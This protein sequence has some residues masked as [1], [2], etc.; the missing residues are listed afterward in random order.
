M[1]SHGSEPVQVIKELF[2]R[3][4]QMPAAPP[5]CTT[6]LKLLLNRFR[7][8]EAAGLFLGLSEDVHNGSG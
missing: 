8:V 4:I 6:T 3:S 5:P 1:R 2:V 7:F